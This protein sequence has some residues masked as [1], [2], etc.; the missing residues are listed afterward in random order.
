M[1]HFFE[2]RRIGFVLFCTFL[3]A[4]A[5]CS[6]PDRPPIAAA[7]GTV[8]LDG[9]P[10]EGATISFVPA[11]GGRPGSGFTDAQ[12]RY[13]ITTFETNDGAKV[14]E[15]QV[16]VIKISGDGAFMPG[17]ADGSPQSDEMS[18]SEI[19]APDS[20]SS[21]KKAPKIDYLVP[22][23]Y[24]SAVTSGLRV[25]VPEEGSDQL[26]LTLSSS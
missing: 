26:N 5:G 21:G 6:G 8:T 19:P 12:G 23:K 18:L 15:H 24:G 25:T 13:T 4:S 11:D 2:F 7:S 1:V 10:V 20:E 22:Q 17:G 14:G 16:A 3:A 9:V